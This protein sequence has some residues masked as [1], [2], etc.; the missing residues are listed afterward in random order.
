MLDEWCVFLRISKHAC[1]HTHITSRF[2]NIGLQKWR[3]QSDRLACKKT[4]RW[5]KLE[6]PISGSHENSS[7]T[8]FTHV[9]RFRNLS[10]EKKC[11]NGL[12]FRCVGHKKKKVKHRPFECH[13]QQGKKCVCTA[14][15]ATIESLGFQFKCFVIWARRCDSKRKL[16]TRRHL[17]SRTLKC[18]VVS[19]IPVGV[20]LPILSPYIFASCP[21]WPNTR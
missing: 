8:T 7:C 6:Y 1:T 21:P 14:A 13:W 12:F 15:T 16:A 19:F 9:Q 4:F 18:Q 20:R 3:N 2:K 11:T 10:H 17:P 5:H